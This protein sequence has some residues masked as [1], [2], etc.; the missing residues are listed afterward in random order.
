MNITE[1][2]PLA[3]A[4]QRFKSGDGNRK[5]KDALTISGGHFMDQPIGD[6]LNDWS[7]VP[8]QYHIWEHIS[9]IQWGED[10]KTFPANLDDV[11]RAELFGEGGHLSVQND[12]HGWHWH[13]I[14]GSNV[15]IPVGYGATRFTDFPDK[16]FRCYEDRVVLWGE[17]KEGH[18]IWWDD[19]VAGANLKYPITYGA[20]KRVQL[21]FSRF[22][23]GGTTAFVWYHSLVQMKEK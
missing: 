20:P 19:R 14:G 16:G 10:T 6:F 21:R 5:G 3:S 22:S 8:M 18:N 11:Q 23:H 7:S 2:D 13:F 1:V 15:A 9:T 12:G 4:W 17:R